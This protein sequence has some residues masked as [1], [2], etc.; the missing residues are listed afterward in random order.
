[1]LDQ[2][3]HADVTLNIDTQVLDDSVR[4]GSIPSVA[5]A[6]DERS[7]AQCASHL[8]GHCPGRGSRT[9]LA[10]CWLATDD[11]SSD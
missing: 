10:I 1:M 8:T 7:E 11:V 6:G 5:L 9:V 3:A 2:V 4:A